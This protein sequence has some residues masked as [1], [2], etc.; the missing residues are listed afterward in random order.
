MQLG[1]ESVQVGRNREQ[2]RKEMGKNEIVR[3]TA[4]KAYL[5]L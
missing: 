4:Q 1:L 3:Y 2:R 5:D